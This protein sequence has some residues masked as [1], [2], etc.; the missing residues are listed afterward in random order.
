MNKFYTNIKEGF[1]ASDSNE[2]DN[3]DIVQT[4]LLIA[5]FAIVTILV[6]GWIGT[7]VTNKGADVAT[8]IEGSTTFKQGDKGYE[9]CA[10]TDHASVGNNSFKKDSTYKD[11]FGNNT[12][13]N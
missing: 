12:S 8:C 5:G 9:K 1:S 7:A 11:R 4:V 10:K 3:A 13:G 6:V 2:L